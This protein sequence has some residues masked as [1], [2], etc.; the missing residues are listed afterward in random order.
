MN[1]AIYFALFL[2]LFILL[3]TERSKKKKTAAHLVNKRKYKKENS[4]MIEIAKRFADKEC[5]VYLFDGNQ[6]T[7]KVKEIDEGAMLIERSCGSLEAVNLDYVLRIREY[8]KTKNGKRKS[9][10]LD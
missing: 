3:I 10:V 9:V 5:I 8:P 6:I 7:G 1:P 2:P 4:E